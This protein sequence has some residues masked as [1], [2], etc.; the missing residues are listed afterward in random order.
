MLWL[1]MVWMFRVEGGGSWRRIV[2]VA[3]ALGGQGGRRRLVLQ[4]GEGRWILWS[5]RV[6]LS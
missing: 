1:G 6:S 5:G 2:R 3:G 4:V